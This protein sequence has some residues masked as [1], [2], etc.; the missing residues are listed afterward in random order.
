[1]PEPLTPAEF[2]FVKMN[3]DPLYVGMRLIATVDALAE[4]ARA[5]DGPA[6]YATS[7]LD[8]DAEEP[9]ARR[10][11]FEATRARVSTRLEKP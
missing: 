10:V 11:R 6:S 1:M 5:A 2:A 7:S 9:E 4:F 3:A 8:W